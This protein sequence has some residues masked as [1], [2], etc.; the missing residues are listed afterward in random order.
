MKHVHGIFSIISALASM[1]LMFFKKDLIVINPGDINFIL[2][3]GML[4]IGIIFISF[5]MFEEK[6]EEVSELR[7][8][9]RYY[10]AF[11]K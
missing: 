2:G 11:F 5:M 4:L 6:Q 8:K 10:Q 3:F 7:K 9:M 1:Y